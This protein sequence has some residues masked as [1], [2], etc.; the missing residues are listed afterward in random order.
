MTD[1]MAHEGVDFGFMPSLEEERTTIR[2]VLTHLEPKTKDDVR[3][4]AAALKTHGPKFEDIFLEW[5]TR[6]G[7]YKAKG[8]WERTKADPDAMDEVIERQLA[9]ECR[10]KRFEALPVYALETLPSLRWIPA[11]ER[12]QPDGARSVFLLLLAYLFWPVVSRL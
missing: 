5:A 4:V 12:L 6:Y 2:R 3:M 9:A 8:L 11:A 10:K 7:R 1:H